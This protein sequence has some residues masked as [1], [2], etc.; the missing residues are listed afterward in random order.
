MAYF[1]KETLNVKMKL[2][3][4]SKNLA[5]QMVVCAYTH[6]WFC[7]V[8]LHVALSCELVSMSGVYVTGMCMYSDLCET[9]Q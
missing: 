9:I 5:L 7:C 6:N 4:H 1:L 2:S 8:Y 3:V